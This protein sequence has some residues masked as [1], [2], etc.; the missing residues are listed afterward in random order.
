M[1]RSSHDSIR[2]LAGYLNEPYR[3]E[4]VLAAA[5]TLVQPFTL[6]DLR[7]VT[8]LPRQMINRVLTRCVDQ[9]ILTR[10]KAAGTIYLYSFVEGR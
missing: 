4:E 6:T 5:R 3:K 8:A 1:A 9:G 10:E 2:H 7:A